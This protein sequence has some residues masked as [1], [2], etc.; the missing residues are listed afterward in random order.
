VTML[1][2]RFRGPLVAIVVLLLSAT[3]A[4]AA[5]PSGGPGANGDHGNHGNSGADSSH[6]VPKASDEDGD[7]QGTTDAQESPE[8]EESNDAGPGDTTDANDNCSTDPTGLSAEQLATLSHGSIVCWAAHQ[9]TPDGYANHGAWV[10]HWAH[11]GKSKGKGA[12]KP[13]N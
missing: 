3:V 5:Q 4:F 2:A 13:S 9:D 10:S 12:N 7:D 8:P 1:I 11:M 6:D